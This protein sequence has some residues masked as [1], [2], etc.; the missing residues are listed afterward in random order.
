[1]FLITVFIVQVKKLVQFNQFPKIPSPT[2]MHFATPVR[3]DSIQHINISAYS[4][5]VKMCGIFHNTPTMSLSRV[6]TAN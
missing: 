2:S 1:M 3:E 5:F 6:T 4:A